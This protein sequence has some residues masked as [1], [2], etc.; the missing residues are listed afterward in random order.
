ME[1]EGMIEMVTDIVLLR[2]LHAD[3]KAEVVRL[4]SCLTACHKRIFGL[5]KELGELREKLDV[6]TSGASYVKLKWSG[7]AAFEGQ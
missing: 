7:D 6:E 2:V 4:N 3:A 1:E 5:E